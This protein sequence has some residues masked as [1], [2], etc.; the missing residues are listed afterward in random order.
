MKEVIGIIATIFLMGGYA[1]Y[2]AAPTAE[3]LTATA[4]SLL[5][6]AYTHVVAAATGFGK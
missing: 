1:P 5:P 2:L 4:L 6:G 3:N